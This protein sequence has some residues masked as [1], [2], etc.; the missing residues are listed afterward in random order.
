MCSDLENKA[1]HIR[2]PLPHCLEVLDPFVTPPL[3]SHTIG[4]SFPLTFA[5]TIPLGHQIPLH[6]HH[7]LCSPHLRCLSRERESPVA[8]NSNCCWFSSFGSELPP[9]Q[10]ILATYLFPETQAFPLVHHPPPMVQGG[11]LEISDSFAFPSYVS[12]T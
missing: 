4:P 7:L 8:L 1:L 5:C 9:E 11:N 2:C 6:L 12:N 10:L 3:L